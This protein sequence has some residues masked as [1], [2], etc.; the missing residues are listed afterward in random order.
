MGKER[1]MPKQEYRQLDK[2]DRLHGALEGLPDVTKV[3]PST[4]IT[5]EPL[6]GATQTFFIQALRQREQGDTIFVQYVDDE[7]A[8]RIAIPPAA[9][10]AIARQRDAL[11]SKSR[12]R[13]SKELAEQRKA[14]GEK[15][16][17]L[18]RKEA[19]AA[20]SGNG[21]ADKSK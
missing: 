4:I 7:G 21:A 15:P 17:F 13:A 8:I 19:A 3:K 18:R 12:K 14:R 20:D 6:I 11:T 1:N 9:A 5:H 2:F 16:A 10:D